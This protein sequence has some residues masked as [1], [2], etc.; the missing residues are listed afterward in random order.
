M[1]P[2]DVEIRIIKPERAEDIELFLE[3]A[4]RIGFTSRAVHLLGDPGTLI[5]RTTLA[6]IRAEL[7][8][9]GPGPC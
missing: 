4:R 3:L 9:R 7:A 2:V 5:L 1:G 8:E 6:G